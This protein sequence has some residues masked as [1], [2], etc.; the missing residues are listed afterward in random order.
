MLLMKRADGHENNIN[1]AIKILCIYLAKTTK[2]GMNM[3]VG[4]NYVII[5]NAAPRK[6]HKDEVGRY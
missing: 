6:S 4:N 1:I 5:L 3:Y 2:H